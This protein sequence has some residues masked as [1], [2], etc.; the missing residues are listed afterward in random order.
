M[1]QNGAENRDCGTLGPKYSRAE[2]T[3]ALERQEEDWRKLIGLT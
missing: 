1:L 3:D 2:T